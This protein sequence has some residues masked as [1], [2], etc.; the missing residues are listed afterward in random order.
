MPTCIS[1]D[2]VFLEGLDLSLVILRIL[3]TAH[4]EELAAVHDLGAER[5][6]CLA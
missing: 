1:L 6:S 3:H 5:E 4:F 2:K